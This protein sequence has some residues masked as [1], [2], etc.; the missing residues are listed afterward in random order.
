VSR[1]PDR[2]PLSADPTPVDDGFSLVEV[3]VALALTMV[4]LVALLPQLLVGIKGAALAND[5]TEAKGVVQGQLERMRNLPYHVAPSARASYRPARHL[6]PQPSVSHTGIQLHDWHQVHPA[7]RWTAQLN[8]VVRL[9]HR[10]G[11]TLRVR[12]D[13]RQLL[14]H[15]GGQG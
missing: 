12:T 10:A 5:V 8:L 9:R 13:H 4:V 2:R 14:P 11:Q 15:R 6:L 1:S 3:I 7:R